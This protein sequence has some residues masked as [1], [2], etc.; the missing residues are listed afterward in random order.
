M[1]LGWWR[2]SIKLADDSVPRFVRQYDETLDLLPSFSNWWFWRGLNEWF[3]MVELNELKKAWY[4]WADISNFKRNKDGRFNFTKDWLEKA[5][6]DIA[7]Q[8][9]DTPLLAKVTDNA[10]D[11]D[12]LMRQSNIRKVSDETLDMIRDT[13]TYD[14]LSEALWR[15]PEICWLKGI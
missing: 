12:V 15:M 3:T 10:Q 7:Y 1:Q 11:F 9:M 5:W 6:W 13:W 8:S 14:V 2:S 4:S